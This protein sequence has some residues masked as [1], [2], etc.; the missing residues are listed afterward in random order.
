MS[1]F[2]HGAKLIGPP[3][4]SLM[5]RKLPGVAYSRMGRAAGTRR[6]K[7]MIGGAAGIGMMANGIG[8]RSGRAA[9]RPNGRP[10]GPYMY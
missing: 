9:D 2:K 8:G 4:P 3:K 5:Q 7:M 10:T 1:I 6:G